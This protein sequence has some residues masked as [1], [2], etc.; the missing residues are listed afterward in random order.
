MC[1]FLISFYPILFSTQILINTLNGNQT[2]SYL[3]FISKYNME[4]LPGVVLL[5]CSIILVS[6]LLFKAMNTMFGEILQPMK[7]RRLIMLTLVSI[8]LCFTL[9]MIFTVVLFRLKLGISSFYITSPGLYVAWGTLYWFFTEF[10]PI[11]FLMSVH[12][13]NFSQELKDVETNED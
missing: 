7:E 8:G 4:I 9:R 13:K 3:V 12:S 11:F 10:A 6:Y 1:I 2:S 5:T